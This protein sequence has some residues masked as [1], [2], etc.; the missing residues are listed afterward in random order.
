[1]CTQVCTNPCWIIVSMRGLYC[2]HLEYAR[3]SFGT[4]LGST[5]LFFRV[6]LHNSNRIHML[7]RSNYVQTVTTTTLT[8][9]SRHLRDIQAPLKV[10]SSGSLAMSAATTYC[11]SIASCEHCSRDLVEPIDPDGLHLCQNSFSSS[12]VCIRLDARRTQFRPRV[13]STE[14]EMHMLV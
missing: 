8:L 3:A 11:R 2:I 14:R 4:S 13:L 1:M 7:K 6:R 9:L 12:R 5:I 10:L